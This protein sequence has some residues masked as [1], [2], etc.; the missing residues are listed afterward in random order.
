LLTFER[1]NPAGPEG[2]S[3]RRCARVVW[4]LPLLLSI[5]FLSG[6]GE[7]ED[8]AES[9]RPKSVSSSEQR[10]D[11]AA[12]TNET[13]KRWYEAEQVTRGS[14][15]FTQHCASCHG[16]NGE[17]AF[18]WRQVGPDGKYPP[19]PLN[20]TGHAWH[21]PIQALG[22][23]I[24]WGAPG[25]QGNMPPFEDR[26]SDEQIVEVIAWFQY[27]WSDEIYAQWLQIERRSRQ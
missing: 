12:G 13:P 5:G 11:A 16:K 9:P 20:G 23:Q 21:H 3:P 19:P 14:A 18:T 4:A 2:T 6:C 26:L 22:S 8:E 7:S 15:L 1:S 27:Q 17:G 24:K 25:G 10:G